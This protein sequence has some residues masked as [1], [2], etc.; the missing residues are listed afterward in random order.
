MFEL[1]LPNGTRHSIQGLLAW[2]CAVPDTKAH[3]SGST[4][5]VVDKSKCHDYRFASN[6]TGSEWRLVTMTD[7]Y[8]MY[9]MD[10]EVVRVVK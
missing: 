2:L 10:V 1:L 3:L 9:A 6:V 7:G 4:I 8:A 5:Y